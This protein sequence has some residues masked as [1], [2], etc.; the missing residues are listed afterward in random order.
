M[1]RFAER[2]NDDAGALRPAPRPMSPDE[3]LLDALRLRVGAVDPTRTELTPVTPNLF[4]RVTA[5]GMPSLFPQEP[6]A[7]VVTPSAPRTLQPR[8]GKQSPN[9]G[10]HLSSQ[11]APVSLSAVRTDRTPWS[12]TFSVGPGSITRRQFRARTRRVHRCAASSLSWQPGATDTGHKARHSPWARLYLRNRFRFCTH[13]TVSE[14][15][16]RAYAAEKEAAT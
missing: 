7:P 16:R 8:L 10:P 4:N 1:R 14:V 11:S 9:P 6:A 12:V 2:P 15:W 13:A 5:A 3:Q